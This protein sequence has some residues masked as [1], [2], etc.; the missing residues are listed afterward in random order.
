MK[1]KILYSA[2]I[3]MCLAAALTGCGKGKNNT[4]KNQKISSA[5]SAP[6]SEVSGS[7]SLN[8][9]EKKSSAESKETKTAKSSE[10]KTLGISEEITIE[11]NSSKNSS[12]ETGKNSESSQSGETSEWIGP[13]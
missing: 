2:I 1:K 8:S 11:N 13:Y 5:V 10:N 12:E 7:N 6:D 9:E 3:I 4:G